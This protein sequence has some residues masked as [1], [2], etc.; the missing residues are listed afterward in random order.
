LYIA[1]DAFKEFVLGLYEAAISENGRMYY[2][3]WQTIK[4]WLMT[5]EQQWR[6]VRQ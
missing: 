3:Y 1:N 6:A 4:H 5:A 2:C